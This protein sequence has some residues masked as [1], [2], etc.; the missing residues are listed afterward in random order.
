MLLSF[1]VFS[2]ALSSFLRNVV[3]AEGQKL[4]TWAVIILNI[5]ASTLLIK[6][7]ILHWENVRGEVQAYANA[8]DKVE[9]TLIQSAGKEEVSI[10]N[11]KSVGDLDSF[12]DNKGWVSGCLAEYYKVKNVKIVE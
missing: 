5:A 11:I 7:V 12:T 10:K 4:F 3:S 6:S 8:F 2:F 1:L 9:P